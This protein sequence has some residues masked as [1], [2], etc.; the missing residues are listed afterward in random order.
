M[1]KFFNKGLFRYKR[2]KSHTVNIGDSGI[3]GNNPIRIQSMTTTDTMDTKSTVDQT[4]R[5]VN[6]GCEFVR[7]T[8]PSVGA[9]KNLS[10]IKNE[11]RMQGY[12]VPLIAD[13]HF[14]PKAAEISAE[15]VE[16]VRIN[17]G[18]YSDTKKFKIIEY[19]DNKKTRIDFKSD[20]SLLYKGAF[21]D[22]IFNIYQMIN[23][24]NIDGTNIYFG[25]T[26][27]DSPEVN[28]EFNILGIWEF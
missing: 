15:I 21:R 17:P 8:A 1:N 3:G 23:P 6:S 5:M 11:L 2:R 27:G 28:E 26:R 25:T 9:A 13:I 10:N 4:I 22:G 16:K 12:N 14:T 19:D 18:N 7:I 20:T 24:E